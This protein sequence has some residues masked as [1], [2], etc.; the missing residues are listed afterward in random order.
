MVIKVVLV[1]IIKVDI[2]VEK[3]KKIKSFTPDRI[4]SLFQ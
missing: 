4:N 1:N 2:A 3:Q